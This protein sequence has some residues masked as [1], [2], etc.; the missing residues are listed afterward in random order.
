MSI[1]GALYYSDEDECSTRNSP[2]L[3][4]GDSGTQPLWPAALWEYF[5]SV[6][7]MATVVLL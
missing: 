6:L 7:V 3:C 1:N 2:F 4:G 5:L